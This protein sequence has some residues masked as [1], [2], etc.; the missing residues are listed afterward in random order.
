[1]KKE[2]INISSSDLPYL[3][4]HGVKGMKWGVRKGPPYPIDVDGNVG[5]TSDRITILSKGDKAYRVSSV[6]NERNSGH[7]FISYKDKDHETYI[8][9]VT[10]I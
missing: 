2:S 3:C 10:V 6:S 5:K 1:M 7:A 4:H 9:H 8:N